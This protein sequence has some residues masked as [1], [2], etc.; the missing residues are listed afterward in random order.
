MSQAHSNEPGSKVKI[1]VVAEEM[2]FKDTFPFMMWPSS[3]FNTLMQSWCDHHGLDRKMV[4]FT[5][6][7][8]NVNRDHTP[9]EYGW[10]PS[11]LEYVVLVQ[12]LKPS[13]VATAP[14]A[15]QPGLAAHRKRESARQGATPRPPKRAKLHRGEADAKSYH[16]LPAPSSSNVMNDWDATDLERETPVQHATLLDI[17]S[18]HLANELRQIYSLAAQKAG[19]LEELQQLQNP[20]L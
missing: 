12:P 5:I 19:T 20:Y 13:S 11:D 10:M 17:K 16:T 7:G 4:H 3:S 9:K 15:A 8:T 2:K 18:P 1:R 14:A 6:D